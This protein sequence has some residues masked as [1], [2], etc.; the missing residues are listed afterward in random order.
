[1]ADESSAVGGGV[2]VDSESE[3]VDG[4]VVVVPAEGD[5]ILRI[6]VTAVVTFCDVVDL[7]PVS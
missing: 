3:H 6:V 4:D 2:G 5:Q 7:E 1:L